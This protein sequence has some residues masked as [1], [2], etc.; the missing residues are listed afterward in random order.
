MRN[1]GH[2]G[3][4]NFFGIGINGKSSEFQ[5]AMGLAL[6]DYLPGIIE[7]RRILCSLYDRMLENVPGISRPMINP[8]ETA[9]NY[10]YYPVI[11]RDEDTLLRIKKALEDEGVRGRR[12]IYP[13]LNTLNYVTNN[14]PGSY[15]EDVSKRVLCLPLFPDLSIMDAER[16]AGVVNRSL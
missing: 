5:A 13:S 14:L 11:L 12:Y 1:F 8:D 10:A 2:N 9:Y 7:K 16:I 6:F 4:E 3:P 15:S